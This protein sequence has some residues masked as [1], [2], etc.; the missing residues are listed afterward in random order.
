MAS[1]SSRRKVLY[2]GSVIIVLTAVAFSVIF[3]FFYKPPTCFDNKENGD[4][5]G[6][7]CG[8]SCVKLCQSTFLP[9]QIQW[10]GGKFEIVAPHLYNLSSYIVNPNMDVGA[11]NVPYKFSVYDNVGLLILEKKGIVSI[12][13]H[14]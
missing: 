14:R 10:G 8:G 9:A 1:W 5:Y 13:P 7:D 2:G 11:V 4:E 3:F 12:S 6:I